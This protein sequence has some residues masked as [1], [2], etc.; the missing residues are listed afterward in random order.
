M[1][2]QRTDRDD[3]IRHAVI[4]Q[5]N[6]YDVVSDIAGGVVAHFTHEKSAIAATRGH[7]DLSVVKKTGYYVSINAGTPP[8]LMTLDGVYLLGDALNT[9][10]PDKY[11]KKNTLDSAMFKVRA[12]GLTDD[13][14]H[15]LTSY[16][17]NCRTC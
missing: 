14:L 17:V 13:E 15:A 2:E 12:A 4:G 7:N 10:P 3:E 16:I 8:A 6:Y 9:D 11:M 5:I 1:D